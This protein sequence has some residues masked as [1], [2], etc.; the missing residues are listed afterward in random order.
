VQ[1]LIGF[2]QERYRK[3]Q[4]TAVRGQAEKGIGGGE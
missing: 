1:I 2:K 4:K 3:L